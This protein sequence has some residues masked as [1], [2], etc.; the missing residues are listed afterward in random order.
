MRSPRS[1]GSERSWNAEA[2]ALPGARVP[3]LHHTRRGNTSLSA[4]T[5]TMRV[6]QN[7]P[8]IETLNDRARGCGSELK[9]SP[10]GT[11][12]KTNSKP[13][14]IKQTGFLHEGT[15]RLPSQNVS[16]AVHAGI[17]SR[18][19]FRSIIRRHYSHSDDD[20]DR[21]SRQ[22]IAP[23]KS[24]LAP[25]GWARFVPGLAPSEAG[26][27]PLNESPTESRNAHSSNGSTPTNRSQRRD[28]SSS[29]LSDGVRDAA[30]ELSEV[31]T[32]T[33]DGTRPFCGHPELG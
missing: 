30:P 24:T 4:A 7:E 8:V 2:D 22:W 26:L 1:R 3:A 23:R 25:C 10:V 14:P 31:S 12:S 28:S 15:D 33:V 11:G 19:G 21:R 27:P 5:A 9:M 6:F 20:I 13:W 18:W 16:R 17:D 29:S 32:P